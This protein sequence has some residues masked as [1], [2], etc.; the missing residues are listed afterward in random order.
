MK[1]VNSHN[2][3]DSISTSSKFVFFLLMSIAIITR[4]YSLP[5][6]YLFQGDQG[7]DALQVYSLVIERQP[8]LLGPT[9]SLGHLYLGPFFYYF[10]APSLIISNFNPVGPAVFQAILSIG[11]VL[12]IYLFSR[13]ILSPITSAIVGIFVAF[14]PALITYGRFSWNPNPSPLFSILFLWSLFIFLRTKKNRWFLWSMFFMT[15][16]WQLHYVMLVL[17]PISIA[18]IALWVNQRFSLKTYLFSLLFLIPCI[19]TALLPLTVSMIK[20]FQQTAS[21]N[22]IILIS[23][24]TVIKFGHIFVKNSTDFFGTSWW[25]PLSLF[26]L[27][28]TLIGIF[29]ILRHFFTRKKRSSESQSETYFWLTIIAAW[30]LEALGLSVINGTME[31]HYLIGFYPFLLLLTGKGIDEIMKKRKTKSSW[32][33]LSLF[34]LVLTNLATQL[35]TFRQKGISANTIEQITQQIASESQGEPF[36]FAL[37]SDDN[38]RKSYRYFF[39]L[40]HVL[41]Q[42]TQATQQ[43]F[44]VCEQKECPISGNPDWQIALFESTYPDQVIYSQMPTHDSSFPKIYTAKIQ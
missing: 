12:A 43:I 21:T 24:T 9:T 19:A 30:G 16:L 18:L 11:T 41:E 25:Q 13:K 4:F 14:S 33:F 37:L 8:I 39:T 3:R 7:R 29:S 20:I 35:N 36:N 17:M 15:I 27:V 38:E 42:E 32:L 22:S 44:V 10:I 2:N 28:F 26:M 40:N 31:T 5:S 34:V 6:T 1:F 23:W